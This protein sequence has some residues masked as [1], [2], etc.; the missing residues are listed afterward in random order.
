[1]WNRSFSSEEEKG[2][3]IAAD[4]SSKLMGVISPAALMEDIG[5]TCCASVSQ[6][7][8]FLGRFMPLKEEQLAKMMVLVTRTD[9]RLGPSI[10]MQEYSSSELYGNTDRDNKKPTSWNLDIFVQVVSDMTKNLSVSDYF[11][12][13]RLFDV[14]ANISYVSLTGPKWY[15][16]WISQDLESPTKSPY[17]IWRNSTET[18]HK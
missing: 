10:T 7:E 2:K 16:A 9:K 1:M 11:S 6:L 13:E 15:G 4:L 17:L 14:D 18:F 8:K 5:F 3:Q 12:E